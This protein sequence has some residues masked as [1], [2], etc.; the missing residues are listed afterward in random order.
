LKLPG[1]LRQSLSSPRN[2]PIVI[3]RVALTVAVLA[4]LIAW[5]G[6]EPL[7]DAIHRVPTEVWLFAAAGLFPI[8]AIVALKW[9]LFVE[10]SGAHVPRLE[11]LRA[12]G[13]GLFASLCLPSIAGGDVVRAGMVAGSGRPLSAV[14]VGSVAD[15]VVDTCALLALSALGAAFLPGLLP[16]QIQRALVGVGA[17]VAAGSIGLPLSLRALPVE[18][19]PL[20]LRRPVDRLRSATDTLV[21]RPGVAL[22]SFALSLASQACL[23]AL[24]A[25][26]GAA[27]GIEVSFAVWMLCWPL[28]KIV[29]LAPVSLGGIGVREAA[30]AG[31]LSAFGVDTASAVGQSLLWQAAMI[32]LGLG[33]GALAFASGG[34]AGRGAPTAGTAERPA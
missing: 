16:P 26:L 9:R 29:A 3:A 4:L 1:A 12:H 22:L 21:A 10:A 19:V 31:L 11:A 6:I 33:S 25:L 18:R 27:M 13:A 20:R 28:A 32:A 5:I 17:L 8:H 15:R 34:A 7:R 23:V 30:L 14:I 2:W 24:N